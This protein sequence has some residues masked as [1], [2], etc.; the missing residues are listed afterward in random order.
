MQ[1]QVPTCDARRAEL[2]QRHDPGEYLSNT[3]HLD[4]RQIMASDQ[5][6]EQVRVVVFADVEQGLMN[7]E[8]FEQLL[9]VVL[10]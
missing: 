1:A 10:H 4:E 5:I 6:R 7:P 9:S 2:D 3:G 8:R